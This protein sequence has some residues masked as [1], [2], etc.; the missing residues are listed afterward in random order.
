MNEARPRREGDQAAYMPGIIA[1][2]FVTWMLFAPVVSV[3]PRCVRRERSVERPECH[4]DVGLAR[5]RG[6]LGVDAYVEG[7]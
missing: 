6:T 7:A 4:S 1:Y 5:L 2:C 3:N